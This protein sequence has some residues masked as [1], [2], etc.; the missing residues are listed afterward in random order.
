MAETVAPQG[1]DVTKKFNRV[2]YGLSIL[3][4]FYFLFVSKDISQAMGILGIA[5]I[6]DPF[7][8]KVS[9]SKRPFYQRAWLVVHGVSILVLL[10]IMLK[11]LL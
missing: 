8:Q 5:L 9:F 3:L 6:F 10:A 11:D 1:R 7:D 2:A 4:A